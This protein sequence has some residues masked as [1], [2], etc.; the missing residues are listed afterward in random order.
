MN[1]HIRDGRCREINFLEH[2]GVDFKERASKRKEKKERKKGKAAEPAVDPAQ[3]GGKVPLPKGYDD[4]PDK[5]LRPSQLGRIM[6][7]LG[8]PTTTEGSH[9]MV[10][11]YLHNDQ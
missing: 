6:L 11:V 2:G 10:Q 7:Q 5:S 4:F 1:C 8:Q 9:A 3:A